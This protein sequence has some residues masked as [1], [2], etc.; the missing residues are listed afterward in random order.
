M[1]F[2][3]QASRVGSSMRIWAAIGN[4]CIWIK[5]LKQVKTLTVKMATYISA[6]QDIVWD[7]IEFIFVMT[8]MILAFATM[9][10]I[11]QSP[12]ENADNDLSIWDNSTP[13]FT[14]LGNSAIGSFIMIFSNFDLAWFDSADHRLSEFSLFIFFLFM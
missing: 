8:L 11:V 14:S 10:W 3:D 5:L 4:C 13:P 7:L 1:G 9:F 12:D 6:I 2:G